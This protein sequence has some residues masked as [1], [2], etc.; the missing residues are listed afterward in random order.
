MKNES[1]ESGVTDTEIIRMVKEM[2]QHNQ[3]E[4]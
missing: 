2:L 4:Y 3:E 1:A